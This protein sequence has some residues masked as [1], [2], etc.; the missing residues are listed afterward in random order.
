MQ[1][2]KFLGRACEISMVLSKEEFADHLRFN[3]IPY[4]LLVKD[5]RIVARNLRRGHL[6]NRIL[7]LLQ[8]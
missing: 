1:K 2:S 6:K 8:E 4:I 7:E 3:A 5:G